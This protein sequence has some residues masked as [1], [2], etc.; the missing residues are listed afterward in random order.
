MCRSPEHLFNHCPKVS[1]LDSTTRRVVFS[2]LLKAQSSTSHTSQ[3]PS[4]TSKRA[5]VQ[6]VHAITSNDGQSPFDETAI[7]STALELDDDVLIAEVENHLDF[8]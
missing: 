8:Q 3:V 5:N 6:C 1:D 2:S 4:N 7:D